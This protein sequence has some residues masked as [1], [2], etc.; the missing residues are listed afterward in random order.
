MDPKLEESIEWLKD[1]N[2]ACI[3]TSGAVPKNTAWTMS[4]PADVLKDFYSGRTPKAGER[5][6]FEVVATTD[7]DGRP[8]VWMQFVPIDN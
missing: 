7:M 8:T 4:A 5:Y 3:V 2:Q 6:C 1:C